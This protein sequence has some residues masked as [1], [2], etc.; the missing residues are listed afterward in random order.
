M[1]HIHEMQFIE[2]GGVKCAVLGCEWK[3]SENEIILILNNL[4]N[5]NASQQSF[6]KECD[7]CHKKKEDVMIIEDPFTKNV[8]GE[9]SE[10]C[11]CG[12]CYQ[13]RVNDI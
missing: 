10:I 6:A 13:N 4:A 7:F 11:I 3:Y 12:D 5:E 1:S 8:N 2:G 9:T